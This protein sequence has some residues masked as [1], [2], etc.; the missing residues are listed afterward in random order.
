MGGLLAALLAVA[1]VF[2]LTPSLSMPT[3]FSVILS[4]VLSPVVAWLERNKF[5]RG[6]AIVLIFLLMG[7]SLGGVGLWAAQTM[8]D[9]MDSFREAAPR[10]YHSGLAQLDSFEQEWKRR[11]PV[12]RSVKLTESVMKSMDATGHWFLLNGPAIMGQLLTCL[13][14]V[15]LLVFGMLK[16]GPTLLKRIFER[17]PNRFFE[18]SFMVSSRILESL[19]DYLRAKLLEALLVG[20]LTFA[21]LFFVGSP[22]AA[23][24]A[25]IAGVTNII[26]Y[27]GPIVGAIPGVVV[28]AFDPAGPVMVWKVAAVYGIANIIDMALIFPLLVAKLVNLHPVV[29]VV[30]VML[31]QE[32]YG[33]IGMLVSIP[34]ATA[35][36]IVLQEVLAAERFIQRSP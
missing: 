4:L 9:E 23:I 12:L 29:L 18:S 28:A 27:L 16:E 14:V 31:G 1:A 24:L 15:P 17:V 8:A 36:K 32:Y 11:Y 30:A 25:A 6:P 22:H 35:A 3:L 5:E 21:G 10:Y 7:T 2:S 34:V 13:F 33:L 26:P 20:A 19:S